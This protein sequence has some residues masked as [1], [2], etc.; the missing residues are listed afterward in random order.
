[1]R[2][3]KRLLLHFAVVLYCGLIVIT[4]AADEVDLFTSEFIGFGKHAIVKHDCAFYK[5]NYS[6]ERDID[7]VNGAV[8]ID[9]AGVIIQGSMYDNT[10]GDVWLNAGS[11]IDV[12]LRISE[13]DKKR[14]KKID[15]E[16]SKL[17]ISFS[18]LVYMNDPSLE[19]YE[20]LFKSEFKKIGQGRWVSGDYAIFTITYSGEHDID[21]ISFAL[22]LKDQSGKVLSLTG[23]KDQTP[24]FVWLKA[25]G[26]KLEGVPLDN[27]PEAR[28]LM[29]T[30]PEKAKLVIEVNR[31]TFME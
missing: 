27:R 10:R 17:K 2:I 5:I 8:W 28:R 25:G 18:K 12:C 9:A 4:A 31:L 3:G 14:I 7:M 16:K 23:V 6:G 11:S 20:K 13:K 22:K 15:L 21:D 29:E 19:S 30:A 1:M 24:G 26:S